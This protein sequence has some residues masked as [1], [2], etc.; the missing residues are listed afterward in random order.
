M[1]IRMGNPFRKK[2]ITKIKCEM[3]ESEMRQREAG[4]G[5]GREGGVV[6][7]FL[8]GNLPVLLGYFAVLCTSFF[9]FFCAILV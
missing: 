6:I 3:R 2:L 4:R 9:A 7:V 5:V 1:R 8:R